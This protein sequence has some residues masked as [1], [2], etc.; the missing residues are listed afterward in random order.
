MAELV[1]AS[2]CYIRG[3]IGRSRVRASLGQLLFL[4]VGS[5]AVV[6]FFNSDSQ[7]LRVGQ[8]SV[9]DNLCIM[10][11]LAPYTDIKRSFSTLLQGIHPKSQPRLQHLQQIG[12][13]MIVV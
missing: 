6:F 9:L 11:T 1:T 12:Y 4:E 2:D 13:Q 10:A 3:G 7:I 8:S 5:I